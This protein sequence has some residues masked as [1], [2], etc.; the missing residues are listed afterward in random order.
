MPRGSRKG[1]EDSQV[2]TMRTPATAQGGKEKYPSVRA[3][4]IEA[5]F[6]SSLFF[7]NK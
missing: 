5:C 4:S 1:R 2:L 3:L 6:A 7:S